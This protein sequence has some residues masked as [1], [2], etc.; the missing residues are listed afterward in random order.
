MKGFAREEFDRHRGVTDDSKI[1]YLVS[2]GKTEFDR[3][4]RYVLEQA[5]RQM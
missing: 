1:R 4:E 2:T 5:A 3:M